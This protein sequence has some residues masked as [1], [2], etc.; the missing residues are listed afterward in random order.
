MAY[1]L[2][3]QNPIQTANSEPS[4]GFFGY[5][6]LGMHDVDDVLH[7]LDLDLLQPVV[8]DFYGQINLRSIEF[9]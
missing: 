2:Q 3:L 6:S 5:Q 4:G 9:N 1:S 7:E 8:Y